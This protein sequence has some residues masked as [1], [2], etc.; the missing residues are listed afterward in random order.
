LPLH[1]AHSRLETSSRLI[2][3]ARGS[4]PRA[5]ST[6]IYER[7]TSQSTSAAPRRRF[8]S[9]NSG[10]RKTTNGILFEE[11]WNSSRWKLYVTPRVRAFDE[12]RKLNEW[13]TK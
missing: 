11:D 8:T 13:K 2:A 4:R 7:Y 9:T 12:R 1:T 5:L 3:V 6:L 10:E